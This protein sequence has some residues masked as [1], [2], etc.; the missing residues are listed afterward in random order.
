MIVV[1][2]ICVLKQVIMLCAASTAKLQVSLY[3]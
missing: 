2:I 3:N 1:S